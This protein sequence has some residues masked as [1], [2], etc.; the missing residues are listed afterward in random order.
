MNMAKLLWNVLV[1]LPILL[2]AA[3]LVVRWLKA[4][5]APIPK[6]TT[7]EHSGPIVGIEATARET[8]A[9][10]GGALLFRVVIFLAASLAAVS[11]MGALDGGGILGLW[12]KWDGFH[13]V[14]LVEQ[15]YAGYAE[16]GQHFF[17][18]FYPLYVWLV[19]LVKLVV[20]NT[21]LSGLLV[22][23]LCYSGGCAY[24]YRLAYRE[25]GPAV[26]WRAVLFLSIFPFSFFF[27]G[28]M[29]EGLFLLTTAAGLYHI[30]RHQWLWAGLWGILAAMTRMHGLFLVGA[31]LAELIQDAKPLALKGA[32]RRRSIYSI[33]RRLPLL[34][35]PLLGT[36]AYLVLNFAVDGS[37][38]AFLGH[39]QV[40]W[41]QGFQWISQVLG[42]LL[43]A[44]FTYGNLMV[45]LQIWLPELLLFLAFFA[46]LWHERGKHRSMF[47]LYAFVCLFF[48][49][50]LSSLLSAGRYLS[51]AIPF[52]LF[53][54]CLT[55]KRPKLTAAVSVVMSMLFT[56]AL[57]IYLTGGQIM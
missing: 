3:G 35:L 34:L 50:S 31:A 56:L 6:I 27:G 15:G 30:R 7:P 9:V 38:L 20:G 41:G 47:T 53:I 37:P 5:G 46:L 49:Y 19:R 32:E 10:F 33:L 54:A 28:M 11:V 17:L 21:L 16:E 12:E 24:L 29:T 48:N 14:R 51:C 45:Q 18:V 22:S 43:D 55:E 52:F 8:A 44:T 39:Q 57:T 25:Y 36:L 26:A 4:G 13:Y 1:S 42:Y 40:R 23:G 2:L